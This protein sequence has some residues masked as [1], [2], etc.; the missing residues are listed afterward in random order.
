MHTKRTGNLIAKKTQE[1]K[2]DTQKEMQHKNKECIRES[3]LL[4]WPE[5]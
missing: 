3:T 4:N 5:Q 2:S 1:D